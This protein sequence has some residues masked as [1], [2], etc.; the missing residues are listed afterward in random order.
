[1]AIIR[2]TTKTASTLV[3][4]GAQA[5]TKRTTAPG[6]T[7]PTVDSLTKKK[8]SSVG[9][10]AF[11]GG[12]VL[13][14]DKNDPNLNLPQ[15]RIVSQT[16]K[17][18]V[19]GKDKEFEVD[20]IVPL[21]LGGSNAEENL[22][23]L[24]K[25]VHGK[26]TWK[27]DDL[28]N[29]DS[30]ISQYRNGKITL[31]QAR[32]KVLNWQEPETTLQFY[33]KPSTVTE[34]T[35]KV[36]SGIW[37]FMFGGIQKYVNNTAIKVGEAAATKTK[38]FKKLEEA[39]AQVLNAQQ[40][41]YQKA[42]QKK[43]MGD[44]AGAEKL[45]KTVQQ[46]KTITAEDILSPESKETAGQVFGQALHATLD[47]LPFV[48]GIGFAARGAK[49]ID[50]ASKALKAGEV[51]DKGVTKHLIDD[52]AR[53][54]D[55]LAGGNGQLSTEAARA[56]KAIDLG[57]VK[58]QGDFVI[59]AEE[60]LK[61]LGLKDAKYMQVV[62]ESS[63]DV[64]SL[65]KGGAPVFNK[66]TPSQL[67]KATWSQLGK[68]ILTGAGEGGAYGLGFGVSQVLQNPG[69]SKEQKAEALIVNT[70]IGIL[71]GGSLKALGPK[72]I[73][74][75]SKYSEA[76][77]RKMKPVDVAKE[78]Q[79]VIE[80]TPIKDPGV[81]ET[82]TGIKIETDNKAL[83]QNFVKN[84]KQLEFRKVRTLP[85]GVGAR[86]EWDYKRR[87][88]IIFTTDA[89]TASN[90]SHELGHYFDRKLTGRVRAKI[91]DLIPNYA[92]NQSKIDAILS[93]Y[94]VRNMGGKATN[95]EIRNGV[96]ALVDKMLPQI[97][98]LAI[99]RGEQRTG[100]GEKFAS[101]F[102]FIVD[103]PKAA[104]KLAP[105]FT[106]FINH[107]LELSGLKRVGK[108]VEY[109][110]LFRGQEGE[111][112]VRNK[113]KFVNL[114]EAESQQ[115][116]L[117]E[118]SSS[119]DKKAAK[120]L[121]EPFDYPKADKHIR[122]TLRKEGFDAVEYSNVNVKGKAPEVHA[123]VSNKHFTTDEATAKV[124]AL[125]RKPGT[126]IPPEKRAA[127]AKQKET[128][129]VKKNEVVMKT[130]KV[131][132]TGET[133]V[134]KTKT[135][136]V[137]PKEVRVAKFS[138]DK[139]TTKAF[140]ESKINA[141]KDVIDTLTKIADSNDNFANE[142]RSATIQELQDFAKNYLG[143]EKLYKSVPDEI[144]QNIGRMKA[145]QQT[146]VDLAA[147]L[148][149]DVTNAN[150]KLMSGDELNA[151]RLKLLRLEAVSKSFAGARTEASHLFSSLK[152][153][154]L[155]GEND[156]MRDMLNSLQD[157]G[158]K[159]KT[160]E[161]FLAG[162][163]KLL[164]PKL[165][166]KAFA[167]WYSAMLSGPKTSIRNILSTAYHFTQEAGL[168]LADPTQWSTVPDAFR[169]IPKGFKMGLAEAKEIMKGKHDPGKFIESGQIDRQAIG[170]TFGTILDMVGRTLNAQ[171]KVFFMAAKEMEKAAL[172]K[173]VKQGKL[174]L[175]AAEIEAKAIAYGEFVVYRNKP[176]G[177][178]G[179]FAE[180]AQGIRKKEAV[181]KIIMPFVRTVANVANRQ[182][183]YI[184]IIN[185]RRI[186]RAF[187]DLGRREG[188][189]ALARAFVGMAATAYAMKYQYGNISGLGP[190]SPTEKQKLMLTGWRPNSIKIGNKWYPY[191][192]F[193]SMAGILALAGNIHDAI[194]YDK[195]DDHSMTEMVAN[196]LVG[197]ANTVMSMSFLTGVSNV[198][199]LM[200]GRKKPLDYFT[201]LGVGL[202]PIP[203]LY[204]QTK[205]IFFQKK[206][207]QAESLQE[208]LLY[209]VGVIG[210]LQ[211]R[212][213][214]FGEQL[215]K[216]A[217]Y[218]ISPS[219]NNYDSISEFI[220]NNPDVSISAP[221]KTMA[222][223]TESGEKRELT[224]SEYTEFVYMT[225]PQL[226]EWLIE[227]IDAGYFG[228]HDAVKETKKKIDDIRDEAKDEMFGN[229]SNNHKKYQR[230]QGK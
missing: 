120:L 107:N 37:N 223:Y 201:D 164:D 148:H 58:S 225:G 197:W 7:R 121:E 220:R 173:L 182:L 198:M 202:I 27:N 196:G 105:E 126:R 163:N 101:A 78:V 72:I 103:Q 82:R 204:T 190:K 140:N 33:F 64:Y 91:S 22:S 136:K 66:L 122:E 169:A 68:R 153:E 162:K 39:N 112:T 145:A 5:Q 89:T 139:I 219:Q 2:P 15:D 228:T 80:T 113:Q 222:V 229:Q 42:M 193:G 143:D 6:L 117:K 124:Y 171:D 74:K 86:F 70:G 132:D 87:K 135:V 221:S 10:L 142:R 215:H 218:G 81:I 17:V 85:E 134:T 109:P 115:S 191:T 97:D 18:K 67:V 147:D 131:L 59:R 13:I 90:L 154:V 185:S 133:K 183:D 77:Q 118:L 51:V 92:G 35:A 32:V 128:T 208:K 217:I 57:T 96:G 1:M 26:K 83:L 123:L 205:D 43:A 119:G 23:A 19:R 31:S 14:R 179:A 216:D 213:D 29:P 172:E 50:E 4:P 211:P 159:S 230:L 49:K 195:A 104:A 141:P 63:S 150:M 146:M 170:G 102:S 24:S 106:N 168:R 54:V 207:Y 52:V 9:P 60:A 65:L 116:L 130:E 34:S 61:K 157:V 129:P 48:K 160:M 55:R 199:D 16:L 25:R 187:K 108:Q 8:V 40:M 175:T 181:T 192:Y 200:S 84:T 111:V 186:Y 30:V 184:P 226:K 203:A 45:L 177:M 3:K 174:T 227:K 20:H 94:V 76:S 152:G 71:A 62:R 75:L 212:L 180:A 178:I 151:L 158:L 44:A 73:E 166:D 41:L 56:V 47:A 156:M 210:G 194:E 38:D 99:A 161:E 189:Q 46:M 144:R 12:G 214:V 28:N 114:R 206:S 53:K 36:A 209:K 138:G 79:E 69:I 127:I 165:S 125:Q 155:P 93:S 149:S 11:P 88:G 100:L 21:W 137:T 95:R 224:P 110:K 167:V 98:E 188:H 176:T